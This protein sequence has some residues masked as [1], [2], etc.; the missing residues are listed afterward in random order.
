MKE[1]KTDSKDSP[2]PSE[3]NRG[4]ELRQLGYSVK[5]AAFVSSLSRR[6][7][8]YLTEAGVLK[9]TRIGTR[10]VINADSLQALIEKGA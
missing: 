8:A 3:R 2:R 1:I 5:Q 10:L 6:K 9:A 4:G 7:I